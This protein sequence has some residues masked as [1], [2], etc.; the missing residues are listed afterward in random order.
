MN[1]TK[2]SEIV[3]N[4]AILTFFIKSQLNTIYSR[5]FGTFQCIYEAF[6][7]LYKGKLQLNYEKKRRGPC[8]TFLW[9]NRVAPGVIAE[10]TRFRTSRYLLLSS[11]IDGVRILGHSGS[12]FS[13]LVY[14]VDDIY[15]IGLHGPRTN[16]FFSQLL[17]ATR[18]KIALRLREVST[19]NHL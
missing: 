4:L 17:Q 13:P 11:G 3:I 9:P 15:C 5:H 14:N 16:A 19:P 12:G 6:M 2:F 10:S 8:T 18:L 7:T 1:L